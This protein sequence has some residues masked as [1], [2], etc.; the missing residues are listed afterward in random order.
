MRN[1]IGCVRLAGSPNQGRMPKRV[2]LLGFIFL[3]L[4][5]MLVAADDPKTGSAFF[6]EETRL[7]MRENAL[8]TAWGESVRRTVLESAQPWRTMSDDDLWDLMFSPTVTRSWMVWS[9]GHCPSCQNPVPMYA[10]KVDALKK[11][12]KAACP[13][14]QELFPKNDFRAFYRSGLDRHGVFDPKRADRRLLFNSEHPQKDDPL[15]SFGVDDGNGYV[16]GENRWRFIGAYLVYGQWKQAVLD[17]IVR[18]SHG[19]LL[20][21]DV[22]YARK[23]IVLLDRVADLYPTFDFKTQAIMYEGPASNGY[24]STWHDACEE[25]RLLALAYDQVYDAIGKDSELPEFLARKARAFGLDN[26][27]K[28]AGDIRRNIEDRILRDAIVHREKIHSNY[29]RTETALAVIHA[30]LG[31]P[32]NRP[33]VMG[34]INELVKKA[35]AVDGVTGE[36]GI[37]NYAS[38]TIGNLAYVLALFDRMDPEFLEEMLSRHPA[39]GKTYRFHIDTWFGASYYPLI[40]DSGTFAQKIEKYAGAP[41]S[42]E[43]NRGSAGIYYP[44]ID[45][46]PF[47]FFWKLFEATR[48]PAY[49]QVLV[50]ENGGKMDD[51]PYDLLETD[52]AA[53]QRRV[54][55]MIGKEGEEIKGGTFDKQQWHLAML[56]SGSGRN[57]RAVWLDYDSWGGHGHADGMNIGLFAKGLDLMPDLGYPPVHYGG[58]ESAKSRW[59]RKT[60]SHN[61]VVI[62]GKDQK[63][64]GNE[65]PSGRTTLWG[66]GNTIKVIRASGAGMAEAR[67]YERTVALIDVSK[68]DSYMLDLFR[69]AGGRDHARFLHGH[70]GTISTTGLTVGPLPDYGFETQMRSFRGDPKARPGWIADWKIEDRYGYRPAGSDL[71]MRLTDLT[72]GAEAAVAESWVSLGVMTNSMEEAWIPALMVR[73]RGESEPLASTFV[74]VIEPYEGSP[75][76]ASVRRL[77]LGDGR[78]RSLP[79]GFVALEIVLA[80]GRR[81]ILFSADGENPP[82]SGPAR[83]N[84]KIMV[85]KEL[86]LQTD[87]EFG[88]V[89][90][91]QNRR[92]VGAALGRGTFLRISDLK[93]AAASGIDF[94]EVA[95]DGSTAR[96]TGASGGEGMTLILRGKKIPLGK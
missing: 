12:W 69:V 4:A 43:P 2:F 39:L 42:K 91:G 80:D 67:Q 66:V 15:R 31:W 52:P 38:S 81:D 84:D 49:V 48:D 55:G 40:G 18:L 28:T 59:Y 26:A 46:S 54:A 57:E 27:K 53:F 82:G 71:H 11:P 16:E 21:G 22:V 62:D 20:T 75:L 47:R 86:G 79:D 74:A 94:V 63:R 88:L 14:C 44:G 76:I 25:T 90:L 96:I 83:G 78:G 24:V 36:K 50:H 72:A 58:W 17:G 35:T 61:T 9:N 23:A 8:K 37:A 13:H 29:P 56:R 95:I 64:I 30:V 6:P 65:I 33:V 77:P 3:S 41:F 60:P 87:A 7:R 92:I 93:I 73:R 32:D 10:W 68:E 34:I 51:L 89:R 5:G 85:Q 1:M 70:F 45:P 19:Y